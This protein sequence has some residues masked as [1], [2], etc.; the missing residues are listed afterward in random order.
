MGVLV[1]NYSA[2]YVVDEEKVSV[3]RVLYSSSDISRDAILPD[4]GKEQEFVVHIVR[5]DILS[6]KMC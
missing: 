3:L 4:M 2:V 1:D 6:R 5:K